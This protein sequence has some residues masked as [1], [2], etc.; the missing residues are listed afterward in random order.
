ME[1][2]GNRK[3]Q[4]ARRLLKE[5]KERG[6][7]KVGIEGDPEN[8]LV[9]VCRL[10]C[11]EEGIEVVNSDETIEKKGGPTLRV[12]DREFVLKWLKEGENG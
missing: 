5:L 11:S 4:E 1:D 8:D 7:D 10:T 2:A 9:D 3:R 6:Y 12:V